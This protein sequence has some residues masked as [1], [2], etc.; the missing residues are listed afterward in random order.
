V[1]S[2]SG[3]HRQLSGLSTQRQS[4]HGSV[5]SF[6]T[7]KH[8]LGGQKPSEGNDGPRGVQLDVNRLENEDF[9][10][11]KRSRIPLD[12][13][14]ITK[15]V[16]PIKISSKKTG[17]MA[18][19]T[20]QIVKLDQCDHSGKGEIKTMGEETPVGPLGGQIDSINDVEGLHNNNHGKG[21]HRTSNGVENKGSVRGSVRTFGKQSIE[22]TGVRVVM[23]S[24]SRLD[25]LRRRVEMGVEVAQR[26]IERSDSEERA[27]C[28]VLSPES[29]QFV[30]GF[31]DGK[32][33]MK[34]RWVEGRLRGASVEVESVA[35]GPDFFENFIV[36]SWLI[37]QTRTSGRA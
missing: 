20:R 16:S 32:K 7:A 15:P 22:Q 12:S 34:F 30:V 3:R 9:P 29:G 27:E 13:E 31:K 21:N 8:T 37:R 5:L 23:E 28:V 19:V 33:A 18:I 17:E 6:G 35:E 14:V 11:V 25:R 24:L 1:S 26:L 36:E 4:V 2:E 10:V